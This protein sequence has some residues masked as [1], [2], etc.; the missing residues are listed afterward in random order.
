MTGTKDGGIKYRGNKCSTC[1]LVV[2]IMHMANLLGMRRYI[3]PRLTV[4][5]FTLSPFNTVCGD[6]A[7]DI[8]SNTTLSLR[9]YYVLWWVLGCL[10]PPAVTATYKAVRMMP[11]CTFTV[12]ADCRVRIIIPLIIGGI[13]KTPSLYRIDFFIILNMNLLLQ[14]KHYSLL[15][16][17]YYVYIRHFFW[18]G[19]L[20]KQPYS[21]HFYVIHQFIFFVHTDLVIYSNFS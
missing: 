19:M 2:A 18:K 11:E 10:H 3:S 5:A 12:H 21:D 16:L 9:Y 15:G 8:Y 1:S 17:N 6:G 7:V 13:L 4:D 14:T 20:K